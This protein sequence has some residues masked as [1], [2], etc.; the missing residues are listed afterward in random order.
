MNNKQI[1]TDDKK[2]PDRDCMLVKMEKYPLFDPVGVVCGVDILF[3]KHVNPNGFI[4]TVIAYLF[5]II[6]YYKN[7]Y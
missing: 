2:N 5:F 4:P 6:K 3:Y 7:K 1:I